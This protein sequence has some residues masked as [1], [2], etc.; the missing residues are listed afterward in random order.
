MRIA[1]V[2]LCNLSCLALTYCVSNLE[3]DLLQL[4]K[5]LVIEVRDPAF[6]A[7]VGM[8]RNELVIDEGYQNTSSLGM[9]SEIH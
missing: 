1:P 2:L 3:K 9:Y 6:D 5:M 7:R 4:L 8:E